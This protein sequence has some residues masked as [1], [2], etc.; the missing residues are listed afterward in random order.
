VNVSDVHNNDNKNAQQHQHAWIPD[1]TMLHR[2]LPDGLDSNGNPWPPPLPAEYCEDMGVVGGGQDDNKRL[3]RQVPIR[4]MDP[5]AMD[6]HAPAG[7]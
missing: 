2:M 3:S 7:M 5:L 1:A 6:D 4:G